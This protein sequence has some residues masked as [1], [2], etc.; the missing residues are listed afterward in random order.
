M[1]KTPNFF[2]E[3]YS[4]NF[5][6]TN[7]GPWRTAADNIDTFFYLFVAD[8]IC[9]RFDS[10]PDLVDRLEKIIKDQKLRPMFVK[11]KAW[12]TAGY[13][14]N[15]LDLTDLYTELKFKQT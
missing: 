7:G 12:T 1:I 11:N 5:R 2:M 3:R 10:P 14:I 4:D 15:R 6:K 8:R 9:F 13:K